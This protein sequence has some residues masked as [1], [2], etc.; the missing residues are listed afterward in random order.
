[1]VSE[2]LEGLGWFFYTFQFR[3]YIYQLCYDSAH[4]GLLRDSLVHQ[5]KTLILYPLR[6]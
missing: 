3:S 2:S 5:Y 4:F 6:K 1:M